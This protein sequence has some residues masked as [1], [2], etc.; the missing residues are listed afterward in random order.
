MQN[1][2]PGVY[3]FFLHIFT[4]FYVFL[5]I[6]PE[7]PALSTLLPPPFCLNDINCLTFVVSVIIITIMNEHHGMSRV[8]NAS[9]PHKLRDRV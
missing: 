3:F 6:L 1:L 5:A 9:N 4:I 2:N 7:L 8:A